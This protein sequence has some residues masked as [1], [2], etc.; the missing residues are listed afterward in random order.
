MVNV[1][2]TVN[3]ALYDGAILGPPN[4][5]RSISR[6]GKG[7]CEDQVSTALGFPS[8]RQMRLP[9]GGALS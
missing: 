6:L 3:E 1:R 5:N 9:E 4:E 7:T 8:K 2:I